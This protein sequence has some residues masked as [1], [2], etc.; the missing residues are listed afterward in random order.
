MKAEQLPNQHHAQPS[1]QP[2]AELTRKIGQGVALA[3][4]RQGFSEL[5]HV[6]K[7]LPDSIP[8]VEQPGQM[9][10]VPPQGVAQNAGYSMPRASYRSPAIRSI[11]VCTQILP[12]GEAGKNVSPPAPLGVVDKHMQELKTS[13]PMVQVQH[14]LE[15]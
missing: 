6:L 13:A 5:A 15:R 8:I 3:A 1:A 10:N 2:Q 11:E 9:N 14:E 7:A 4:F 12:D